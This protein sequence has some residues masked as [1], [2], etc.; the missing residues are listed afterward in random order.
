MA[1]YVIPSTTVETIVTNPTVVSKPVLYACLYTY[2]M[3]TYECM[4]EA[5][6]HHHFYENENR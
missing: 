6:E 4:R 5:V 3:T 2:F 1:G